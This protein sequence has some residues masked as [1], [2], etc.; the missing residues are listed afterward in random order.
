[1]GRIVDLYAGPGGWSEALRLLGR[2]TDELGVE[3]DAA[4]CKTRAAAGH[5]TLQ[6]DVAALLEQDFADD[7]EGFIASP[8]CQAFSSA[9]KQAGRDLIPE[10]LASIT[11]RRWHDRADPDPRVWLIV[12]LGR[13]LE[14]LDPEWIA[15]EQV[16]S[17][18]P[19]WRA[20]ADLLRARGYSVWTGLLNAANYGVPQTR[21][22]AVLMASRT[23]IVEPPPATHEKDPTPSLFGELLPWVTMAEALG[24]GGDFRVGFPRLDDRG[25]SPDGYRERD[26]R[27]GDEPANTVTEKARSWLLNTGRAWPDG[28]TREDAQTIDV[29]AEP[30]PTLTAKS[31]GQWQL[32]AG[33]YSQATTRAE[34]EPAP[35]LGA[36]EA[37]ERY[38]DRAGTEAIRL[39]VADALVLQSFRIDYPVSGTKTKQFEQVGNAVP[40]RLAWHV[41]SALLGHAGREWPGYP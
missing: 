17:V 9:G 2:Q 25:D 12:D 41:L 10:L 8:P 6:A 30:A 3:W 26:W 1:M 11:A 22:R 37:A 31:G 4:A 39:T 36:E 23:R 21:T 28:G 38:G 34:D 29:S 7:L 13:F 32:R 40:P 18:L 19:L 27:S 14:R 35:T 24:I 33:R 20:Y 5:R 16:P 15:L